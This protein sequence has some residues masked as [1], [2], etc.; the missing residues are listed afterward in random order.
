M[1]A[2]AVGPFRKLGLPVM[3]AAIKVGVHYVDISAEQSFIRSAFETCD[4]AAQ[5]SGLTILPG[6]GCDFTFAY[7]AAALIDEAVGRVARCNSFHWPNDFAPSRG[8]LN[9]AVGM[10]AEPHFTYDQ[11]QWLE[12]E[13]AWRPKRQKFPDMKDVS[14]TVPFPGGD[15][16]LLPS[17]FP[18]LEHCTSH[19]V[20]GPRESRG[21]AFANKLSP[22][23]RKLM[24]TPLLGVIEEK[25]HANHRDP[26]EH[27]R[28]RDKWSFFVRGDG[29]EG[30]AWCRIEGSDTYGISGVCVAQAAARL[31]RGE[32]KKAG[33]VS[34]GKAFSAGAFLEA[35]EPHGV[36]FTLMK[37]GAR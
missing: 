24:K 37:P 30:R 11:G 28:Q 17:D 9:S 2:N 19:L 12:Q 10:V 35:L 21:L 32:Q 26:T 8:T 3:Q 15:V 29:P 36:K 5:D 22:I 23:T 4:A 27:Q 16:I 7:C 31:A 20:L 25:I 14:Y 13:Y 18:S 6:H 1:V 34:T 33:V